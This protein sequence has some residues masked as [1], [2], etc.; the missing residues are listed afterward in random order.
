MN[1][2]TVILFGTESGNAEFAAEDMA[3]AIESGR[4]V[5]VVDMTDF[6]VSEFS[7]GTFYVIISSTHGEGEVPSGARP[8]VEALNSEAPDLAG[9]DFA[10]FGLGDSTYE[11]YSRGSEII[12][13]KL[14]DLGGK[15]LGT[16]GRHDAS[17]GSLPNDAAVEWVKELFENL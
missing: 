5:I 13:Q 15:R 7:A 11:N 6:E 10:V 2:D 1:K 12:E 4:N 9:V 3:A 14:S 16:Y 8:F 17:D